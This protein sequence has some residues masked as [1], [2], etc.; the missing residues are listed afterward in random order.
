MSTTQQTVQ[1]NSAQQ[2]QAATVASNSNSAQ[3]ATKQTSKKRSKKSK[4]VQQKAINNNNFFV[5]GYGFI[6]TG[7]ALQQ[8]FNFALV[9]KQHNGVSAQ[10]QLTNLTAN[11]FTFTVVKISKKRA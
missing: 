3:V 5:N 10:L 8:H 1:Q 6:Q 4:V 2:A 9:K 11:S 7:V